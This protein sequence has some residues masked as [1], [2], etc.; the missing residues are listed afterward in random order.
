MRRIGLAVVLA[1]GL[2]LAPLV[3]EAQEISKSARVGFLSP[4]IISPAQVRESPYVRAFRDGLAQLGYRE[5]QNLVLEV[6]SAERQTDLGGPAQELVQLKVDVIVAAGVSSVRSAKSA[7]QTIPIVGVFG[8]DPVAM[9]L[10]QS[11]SRPGG[12]LT[13]FLQGGLEVGKM[14]QLLSEALPELTR[15]GYVWNPDNPAHRGFL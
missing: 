15:V 14:L 6:R 7:T 10:A 1:L 5:G 3:A 9:G 8:G 13:G 4:G 11:I 12:N 2:A